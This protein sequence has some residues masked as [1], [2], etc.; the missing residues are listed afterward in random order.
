MNSEN[1][2]PAL[3]HGD[4][5]LYVWTIPTKHGDV[6]LRLRNGSAG[7]LLAHF[8]LWWAEVLEPVRG[9]VL[10]DWGWAYRP[11]RGAVVLSNHASGTAADVNATKYPL[12]LDRMD[13]TK[14][15]KIRRRLRLY[16]RCLRWGGDYRGRLDQMHTEIDK[17][18]RSCERVARLLMKSPRGKRILR[19]NPSQRAVIL[20]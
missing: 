17:P 20:S 12:G 19:A 4:S 18:L 7:F 1:G 16:A 3:A 6:M 8:I 5:R 13:D 9:S 2:W 10:D 15:R 11:V 14:K